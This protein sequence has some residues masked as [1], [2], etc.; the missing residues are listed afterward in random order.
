MVKRL[1][2]P[3]KDFIIWNREFLNKSRSECLESISALDDESGYSIRT[4][5]IFCIES[6]DTEKVITDFVVSDL[7]NKSA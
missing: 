7:G 5:N 4:G 3:S 6:F 1:V 2:N